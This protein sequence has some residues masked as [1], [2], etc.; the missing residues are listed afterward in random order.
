[1]TFAT[2]NRPLL[3]FST[4]DERAT[5]LPVESELM[6]RRRRRVT[7]T[8]TTRTTRSVTKRRR[9][10][11]RKKRRVR[12]IK[13][14]RLVKGRLALRVAGYS[15]VQHIPPSQLVKFVPLAK[16]KTAASRVLG[17]R[18]RTKKQ[19]KRRRKRLAIRRR[20]R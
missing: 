12:T 10:L 7:T 11:R 14:V 4:R 5:L 16:L 17:S 6:P 8:R 15:G 13:G 20:R 2:T 18:R 3:N 1:M 19:V 9:T